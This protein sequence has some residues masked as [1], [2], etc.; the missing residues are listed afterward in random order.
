NTP[1]LLDLHAEKNMEWISANIPLLI[2]IGLTIFFGIIEAATV[3]VV[4]IWFVIGCAAA[5]IAAFAGGPIWLQLLLAI[6]VSSALLAYVR[7]MLVDQDKNSPKVLASTDAESIEGKVGTVT[8]RITPESPGQVIVNGIQWTAQGMN[9][10]DTF[11]VNTRVIICKLDGLRCLV[12]K[13]EV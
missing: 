6:G 5:G 10:D 4:S 1:A 3:A 13:Y 12:D 2:W 8:T 7:K 9:P 11:D